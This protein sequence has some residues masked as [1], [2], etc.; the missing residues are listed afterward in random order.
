MNRHGTLHTYGLK[1]KLLFCSNVSA[2]CSCYHLNHQVP[3]LIDLSKRPAQHFWLGCVLCFP[4]SHDISVFVKLLA[5]F[6]MIWIPWMLGI[7]TVLLGNWWFEQPCQTQTSSHTPLFSAALYHLSAC[8]IPSH[9]ASHPLV[10]VGQNPNTLSI[11]SI[12][13]SQICSSPTDPQFYDLGY[14]CNTGTALTLR[15]AARLGQIHRPSLWNQ[16]FWIHHSLTT[17]T[18]LSQAL[19]NV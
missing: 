14:S 17:S 19:E 5:L 1:P 4:P 9:P 18:K 3:V 8:Q 10:L 11:I 2:L 7:F 12:S 13:Y 16:L 6:T 15:K